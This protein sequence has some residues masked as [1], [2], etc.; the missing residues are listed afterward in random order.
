MK[1]EQTPIPRPGAPVMQRSFPMEVKTMMSRKRSLGG[2]QNQ[3]RSPMTLTVEMMV[4]MTNPG[5][6][7]PKKDEDEKDNKSKKGKMGPSDDEDSGADSRG[8]SS[9]DNARLVTTRHSR[10]ADSDATCSTETRTNTN[11][12]R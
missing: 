6:K 11:G 2:V 12:I 7:K 3:I 5:G 10:R 1:V 9:G 8:H 4:T